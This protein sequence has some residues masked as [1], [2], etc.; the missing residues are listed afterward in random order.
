MTGNTGSIHGVSHTPPLA[1]MFCMSMHRCAASRIPAMCGLSPH[2]E[3]NSADMNW[4]QGC[5]DG[6]DDGSRDPQSLMRRRDLSDAHD[7]HALLPAGAGARCLLRRFR[8]FTFG[9]E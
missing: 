3:A 8:A 1:N 5:L 6:C 7:R 9:K 4:F 2:R